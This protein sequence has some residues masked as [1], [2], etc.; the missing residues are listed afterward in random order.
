M[1]LPGAGKTTLAKAIIT[2]LLDAGKTV[3]WFN[4][5]E[6]RREYNDW[7][8][9]DAGRMRQAARMNDLAKNVDADFVVCDFVCPTPLLRAIFMPHV[10]IWVDTIIAGRYEDTNDKF[11]PPTNYQYRVL[12]QDA[13]KYSKEIV[14]DIL[15][16]E[17]K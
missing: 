9:S 16:K 6:V 14:E 7:D 13:E 11:T 5:D 3:K 15:T 17:N 2:R 4:A 10:N 1:G 8:F 12:E